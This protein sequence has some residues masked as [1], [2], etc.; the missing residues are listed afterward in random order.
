M[1]G[2]VFIVA[3]IEQMNARKRTVKALTMARNLK[4]G[5]VCLATSGPVVHGET[6]GR[7]MKK[8]WLIDMVETF[9]TK[10]FTPK[11]WPEHRRWYSA[12]TVVALKLEDATEPEL[13]GE[14]QLFGILAPTDFLIAANRDGDWTFPSIEIGTNFR[15]TGKFFLDG[16]GVTD[17]PA[18]PGVTELKFSSKDGTR[19]KNIVC[20]HQFNLSKEIKIETESESL[21]KRV[22]S[23][24][25]DSP[26]QTNA[27]DDTMTEEQMKALKDS[28]IE[29]IDTKFS[30]IE[31]RLP[32][33]TEGENTP[34]PAAG[35]NGKEGDDPAPAGD[36]K[37]S[38]LQT[39]NEDLKTRLG[40]LETK[41]AT[42]TN[43]PNGKNTPAGE[44]EGDG[45][46]QECL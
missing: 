25:S 15:G 26:N 36:D 46:A 1:V 5:W 7:F 17:Q 34:A 22:F 21:L 32:A 10:V 24:F 20:G 4:T 19:E 31:S 8:E 11:I 23:R 30:S 13:K 41:F 27:E 14:I 42:M 39:E 28:L 2:V 44:N 35:N 38:A 16:L 29:H 12:G 9:N 33:S 43:T 45:S 3:V 6:D 18:S 37:F 40:D